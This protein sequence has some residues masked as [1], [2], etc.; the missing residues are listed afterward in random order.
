M[1]TTHPP[2]WILSV[3]LALLL[4]PLAARSDEETGAKNKMQKKP[5]AEAAKPAAGP[6]A[7]DGKAKA[8]AEHPAW[9][10]IDGTVAGLSKDGHGILIRTHANEYQVFATPQSALTLDGQPAKLENLKPGDRVDSCEFSAKSI[11]HKLA[12]TSAAKARFQVS[13]PE[14]KP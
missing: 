5:A 6:T 11:I 12:V 9:R 10:T 1:K 13:A 8:A 2:A 7:P 3:L 14:K 4:S